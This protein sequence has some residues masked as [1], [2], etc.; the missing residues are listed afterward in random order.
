M[1]LCGLAI[2]GV[3]FVLYAW[4][5][6]AVT[7]NMAMAVLTIGSAV[8]SDLPVLTVMN[9]WFRRRRARAMALVMLPGAVA[10]FLIGVLPAGLLL[11]AAAVSIRP[12]GWRWGR[13]CSP[14]PGRCQG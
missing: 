4:A 9:N 11:L 1:V 6:T 2:I 7:I 12:F 8:G 13:Y 10:H 3:G 14:W 5:Q